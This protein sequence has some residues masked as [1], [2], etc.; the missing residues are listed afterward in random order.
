MRLLQVCEELYV[1]VSASG[2][3]GG[4]LPFIV[5]SDCRRVHT[6]QGEHPDRR[7]DP[8]AMERKFREFLSASRAG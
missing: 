3:V 8:Y 2:P 7:S 4:D 6:L 5:Y 1:T